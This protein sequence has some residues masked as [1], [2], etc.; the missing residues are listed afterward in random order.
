MECRSA[1]GACCI[2]PAIHRPF[3][4]MPEGKASGQRC[5]HLDEA[6]RCRLFGDPRRP[7]ACAD[8]QPEPDVCGSDRAE[9]LRLIGELELASRPTMEGAR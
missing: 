2:A 1:C 8:F 6:M 9:A 7:R 3:F 5:L 4:G